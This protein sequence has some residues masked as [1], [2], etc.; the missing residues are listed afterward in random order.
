VLSTSQ[1]LQATN[2]AGSGSFELYCNVTSGAASVQPHKSVTEQCDP[3]GGGDDGGG[4]GD[5]CLHGAGGC[6]RFSR[7]MVISNPVR[8]D[9]H[10][11]VSLA[12][13]APVDVRAYDISGREVAVVH[14]GMASVGRTVLTWN[15]QGLPV[16]VYQVRMRVEDVVRTAQAIVVR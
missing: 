5:L 6:A 3:G 16:G 1:T 13:P 8:G 9:V 2:P 4:G 10:L 12:A 14:Q 15:T 7:L 11:A